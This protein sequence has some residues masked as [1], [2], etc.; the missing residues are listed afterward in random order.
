MKIL[1]IAVMPGDGIGPEV[2]AEAVKVLRAVES[3][4]GGLEFDLREFPCGAAEYLCHVDPPPAGTLAACEASDAI[5]LG[6]MGLPAIRWPDGTEM[7]P[8]LDLREKLDLYCGTRPIYLYH[9]AH[10]P[11]KNIAAGQID[12]LLIRENTEG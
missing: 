6:A 4:L 7:A 1:R 12:L 3:H 5:L 9:E 10:T 2:M 11:L 8:Q